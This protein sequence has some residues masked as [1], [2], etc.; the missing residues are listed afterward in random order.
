MTGA[1]IDAVSLWPG[2]TIEV[3]QMGMRACAVRL[4]VGKDARLVLAVPH[5]A[6][7]QEFEVRAEGLKERAGNAELTGG[8]NR[9]EG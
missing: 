9:Q 1:R 3:R 8:K 2:E 5:G 6:D 4:W 7:W